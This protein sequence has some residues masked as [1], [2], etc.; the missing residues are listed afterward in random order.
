MKKIKSAASILLCMTMLI[1]MCVIG[2]SAEDFIIDDVADDVVV[3][4]NLKTSQKQAK[5]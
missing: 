4:V 2:A 3:Y 5:I 1:S